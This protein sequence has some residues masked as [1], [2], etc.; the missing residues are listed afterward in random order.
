MKRTHDKRKVGERN[1][2]AHSYS[3]S[4][5]SSFQFFF[6][7]V[8]DSRLTNAKPFVSRVF[9]SFFS[10]SF[11][12][13]YYCYNYYCYLYFFIIIFFFFFLMNEW[14]SERANGW[15]AHSVSRWMAAESLTFMFLLLTH[16]LLLL[17]S[18]SLSRSLRMTI[19]WSKVCSSLV[20][21][22]SLSLPFSRY[23]F[24]AK[25]K[26]ETLL[27]LPNCHL[28]DFTVAA[29]IQTHTYTHTLNYHTKVEKKAFHCNWKNIRKEEK[30]EWK[31]N[32]L[33]ECECEHK[34]NNKPPQTT[35]K[36]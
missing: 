16:S 4:T 30:G 5:T 12:F 29:N 27:L 13:Y 7:V 11:F 23:S 9:F 18:P 22:F 14:V 33:C 2:R 26:K 17:L 20:F 35:N 36:I 1:G 3:F 24:R 19:S 10:F 21:T 25:S 34:P 15:P 8:V 32:L 31:L 28:I 6:I